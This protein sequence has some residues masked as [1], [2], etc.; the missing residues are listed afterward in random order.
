MLESLPSE[1]KE[2][3]EALIS[4]DKSVSCFEDY[5]QFKVLVLRRVDL[6]SLIH[7]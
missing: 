6:L 5:D 4:S 7:I 1:Y 2:D 3:V